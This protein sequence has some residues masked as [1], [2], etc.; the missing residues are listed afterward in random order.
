MGC[1]SKQG[2]QTLTLNPA[3]L[4]G[5]IQHPDFSDVTLKYSVQK[6]PLTSDGQVSATVRQMIRYVVE[7][8][9]H[10]LIVED[11]ANA[12]REGNGDPVLGAYRFAKRH[13]RFQQDAKTG[14]FDRDCVEV[15]VR[16]VDVALMH[17]QGLNVVGD[18]DDFSMYVAALLRAN[19]V[20]CFFVTAAVD[21]ND[22]TVYS[23]VYVAAYPRSGRVAVDASHGKFCG[24][25][26]PNLFG[27][28]RE[29]EVKND[30]VSVGGG[31]NVLM[32]A[33]VAAGGYFL[34]RNISTVKEKISSLLAGLPDLS[35]E[36][37]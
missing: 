24:W 27:K 26:V 22:P 13:I 14:A 11:A 30:A 29:W 9:T 16:P 4:N 2:C 34:Y 33:A 18:C 20:P 36:D 28:V 1:Q 21:A 8:C 10:P 12:L 17:R 37:N 5:V 25:E 7:D 3:A 32:L 35:M 31:V 6:M 15:L 19:F 23:H